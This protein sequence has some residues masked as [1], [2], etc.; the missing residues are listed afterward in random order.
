MV[1]IANQN[2]CDLV[3][4]AGDLF[5]CDKIYPETLEYIT[6]AFHACNCPICI[7][8]GNHDYHRPGGVY[9]RDIWSD[10]IHIFKESKIKPIDFPKINTTIWGAAFVS[11]T[12]PPLLD[13]LHIS[14]T[15]ALNIGLFHGDLD[16]KNSIYN[17]MSQEAV[18]Q[19]GLDYLALGHVHKRSKFHQIDNTTVAYPG[20]FAGRGFDELGAKGVYLGEI[21]KGHCNMEFI[22]LSG[23]KYEIIPIFMEN[24]S[25]NPFENLKYGDTA[26]TVARLILEGKSDPVDIKSIEE[27][28]APHFHSLAIR[29]HTTPKIDLWSMAT[30]DSLKGLFLQEL[31]S[32]L[33]ENPESVTL[34]AQLGLAVMEGREVAEP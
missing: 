19:S 17:P 5:D 22:P 29:D 7:A 30:E 20:C 11:P 8:P 18:A 12:A 16:K 32:L 24:T 15:S 21:Q 31:K 26:N 27:A 14:D 34:A 6:K 1:E 9:D 13:N 25:E 4:L 33:A 3:L 10:N 23:L 2:H 28:L